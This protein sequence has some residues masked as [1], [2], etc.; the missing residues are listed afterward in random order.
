[1]SR[2]LCFKTY[3]QISKYTNVGCY[4]INIE[5]VIYGRQLTS[6]AQVLLLELQFTLVSLTLLDCEYSPL[7]AMDCGAG[8]IHALR[9]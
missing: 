4:T 7:S 3:V 5:T 1:M 6:F 8:E 9:N 2:A